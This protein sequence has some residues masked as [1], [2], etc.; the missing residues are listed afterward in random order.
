MT[1]VCEAYLRMRE[2][3]FRGYDWSEFINF[4]GMT[5]VV[6]LSSP[7]TVDAHIIKAHTESMNYLIQIVELVKHYKLPEWALAIKAEILGYYEDQPIDSRESVLNSIDTDIIDRQTFIVRN[8][9]TSG[10]VIPT[11]I[12]DCQLTVFSLT[13]ETPYMQ[14]FFR[15]TDREPVNPFNF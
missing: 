13:G 4:F 12:E 6:S 14:I 3:M 2:S 5:P 10:E 8:A 11:R 7:E 9:T 15:P 1:D